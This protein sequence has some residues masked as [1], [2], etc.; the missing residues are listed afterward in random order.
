M[1]P[2]GRS[3]IHDDAYQSDTYR[4]VGPLGRAM[5]VTST[6]NFHECASL[7]FDSQGRLVAVC[8][9]LQGPVLM[10]F[11]P[12]TLA[13]LAAMPLPPRTNA[14]PDVLTDFSGGG[15]FYLD[16]QDRVVTATTTRHVWIIAE[17]ETPAGP[18]FET[19]KDLDLSSAVPVGDAIISALPDWKGSIW[20]AS[21]KGVVGNVDPGTG[22]LQSVDLH[23]PI[24]NSFAID[25]RGGV[26]IVSDAA[27]Y[28]FQRGTGAPRV[29]WRRGYRNIGVKKPGQTQAGSGTTPTLMGDRFVSI[30]DNSDPMN[31]LVLRRGSHPSRRRLVCKTSVFKRGAGDTDQSLIATERSMIVENNYGYSGLAAT[32]NGG[33]TEPGIERVDVVPVGPGRY[34]CKKIWRSNERAPSVVPKLSLGAGLVYTWTKPAG[35]DD[36]WYFTAVDFRS[37]R[38]VYKRLAGTGLGHNNHYAPII[39][40]PHRNAYVATF[41]GIVAL[42]DTD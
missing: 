12:E 5:A 32:E 34:R 37:G 36:P 2:N 33:T 3:N 15:Y 9:G 6:E 39:L 13:L 8:P 31:V 14:G 30:T 41:G 4:Q 10:M 24:G 19:Q 17:T 38:T 21:K 25:A 28:R 22:A 23:E 20:F 27:L 42:R 35:G 29:V 7:T 40:G 26:Y 18:G 1:A 11:D 16:N